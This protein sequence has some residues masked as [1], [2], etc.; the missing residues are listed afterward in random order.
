MMNRINKLLIAILLI[1]LVIIIFFLFRR[2]SP[3]FEYKLEGRT[4]KLLIAKN[5]LEWTTGL[6][7]YKKK[8][9]L[10]GAQGMIFLFPNKE[11]RQFWNEGTYLDLD[12]YWIDNDKVIG[13]DYLP[14]IEK[15]KDTVIISSPGEADKVVEIVR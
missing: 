3:F 12:V 4:Y 8:D 11:T 2:G 6:M 7:G 1:L 13:K 5:T 14:S 10:K 9:E 15:S